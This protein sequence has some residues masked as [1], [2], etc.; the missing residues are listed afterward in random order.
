MRER[1]RERERERAAFL[2][3]KSCFDV[4]VNLP[5]YFSVNVWNLGDQATS[6]LGISIPAEYCMNDVIYT[7]YNKFSNCFVWVSPFTP[8]LE[9]HLLS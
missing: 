9:F 6:A 7:M 2:Y 8:D 3:L 4:P 1:E 5:S